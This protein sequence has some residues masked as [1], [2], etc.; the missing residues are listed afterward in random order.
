MSATRTP[1]QSSLRLFHL[2]APP[3]V[4]LVRAP[5]PSNSASGHLVLGCARVM[6]YDDRAVALQSCGRFRVASEE[7]HHLA[8]VIQCSAFWAC[9]AASWYKVRQVCDTPTPGAAAEPLEKKQYRW[10]GPRTQRGTGWVGLES[11]A[12]RG[13]K[14]SGR[15]F[16]FLTWPDDCLAEEEPLPKAGPLAVLHF[17]PCSFD[18]DYSPT[19]EADEL[20]YVAETWLESLL[21]LCVGEVRDGGHMP[22]SDPEERKLVVVEVVVESRTELHR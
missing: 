1:V 20:S 6:A 10:H 17:P 11:R 15:R 8:S 14:R 21:I 9:S 12:A 5:T 4:S 2:A 7:A 16:A 13:A 18:A 19:A 22:D 3:A